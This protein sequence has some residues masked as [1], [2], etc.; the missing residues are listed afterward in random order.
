MLLARRDVTHPES[1][2]VL[3]LHTPS[4]AAPLAVLAPIGAC[5]DTP[6]VVW[7]ISEGVRPCMFVMLLILAAATSAA[8]GAC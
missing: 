5:T 3:T 8:S 4:P 1:R 6:H 7:G 2:V